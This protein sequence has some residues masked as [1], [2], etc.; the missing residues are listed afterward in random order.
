[1]SRCYPRIQTKA[2]PRVAAAIARYHVAPT[3][4]AAE[5][6]AREA[7]I[8]NPDDPATHARI[9]LFCSA[10]N[11]NGYNAADALRLVS[12]D[13]NGATADERA[14]RNARDW[15]RI[16]AQRIGADL[17]P[18]PLPFDLRPFEIDERAPL[19]CEAFDGR[20]WITVSAHWGADA[21]AAVC[22]V[23][24]SRRIVRISD[25]KICQA[26]D[27]AAMTVE[28]LRAA[29]AGRAAD[30]IAQHLRADA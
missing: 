5:A 18:F 10:W 26:F 23:S 2:R 13:R 11:P 7:G 17:E 30:A 27:G 24:R 12:W 25:G 21:N 4:A 20:A 1:M 8:N 29:V 19:R 6:L 22:G 3:E 9:G 16:N 14:L 15:E 28:D